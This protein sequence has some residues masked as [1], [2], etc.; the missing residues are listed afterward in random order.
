MVSF[1]WPVHKQVVDEHAPVKRIQLRNQ[2]L[3][4][5]GPDIQKLIRIRNRL[6]P[7][8]NRLKWSKYKKQRNTV[9]AIQRRAIKISVLI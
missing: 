9:T 6:S 7:C 4:W 3:P 8:T 1:V 5:I 2:Q